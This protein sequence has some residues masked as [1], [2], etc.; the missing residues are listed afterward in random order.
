MP[1]VSGLLLL[2]RLRCPLLLSL[3]LLLLL[4]RTDR[5]AL[6]PQQELVQGEH[7]CAHHVGDAYRL[8]VLALFTA[9]CTEHAVVCTSRTN[10]GSMVARRPGV[11]WRLKLCF[12]AELGDI[13]GLWGQARPCKAS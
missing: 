7:H 8:Q 13:C 2:H 10:H 5:Q 1:D 3:L 6:G 4:V 9:L 11:R 12:L